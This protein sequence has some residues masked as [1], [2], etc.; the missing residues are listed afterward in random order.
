[1]ADRLGTYRKKRDFGTTPE[2]KGRGRKKAEA[3][4]FVVQEHSA[5]R[6]HWDLRLEHD[7]SLASWALPRG[8][9]AHPD[10]NRLAVQTED[11]PL[12]YLEFEGDIP[13]GEYGAGTMRVW[14]GGTY[15]AEKFR[16]GEV[17][18]TFNGER[19]RG[20][21]ALFRTRDKDW[22][23]HRMDPPED[24]GYQPMPDRLEPMLARS[25]KLPSNEQA[26]GF[27]VKWDGIRTLLFSDHGHITLQGRNFS[28]FTPRYPEVREFS[29][30][31]GARRLILDG[32]VVAFDKE[33]RPSFELL[34][35]RMHLASDSAVRRRMR[36]IP[37]TY[38]IFDLLY[39]DGRLTL[40]L[41]YEDRRTL[42]EE[43]E[44]EG[45]ALAH[46]RLPP[47]RGRRAA[48]GHPPAR[49]R[50][51]DREAARPPLRARPARLAL[52]Q[53][54]ER[55]DPGHRDRRLDSGG[56]R[57]QQHDRRPGGGRDGGGQARLRRQ[58]RHRLHRGD[59]RG[60]QARARAAPARHEPV[61]GAS[62]AEGDDLRRAEAGRRGRV[63]PVDEERDAARALLQGPAAGQGPARMHPRSRVS[64]Y[65][66]GIFNLMARA[67]WS[68]AISFGLVNIPVKLFSAVS[69][70]TVRFHQIDSKSGARIKQQR[71]NQDGEEVK[72][73]DIVK[74][75]EISPE[76]YVMIAPEELESLEPQKTR[77]ID[78]EAFVDLEQIDP[79]YYDHP[80]YLA[81]DKGAEKAYKLLVDAMDEASKVAVA[82]VVIRSKES[83]VA[84]RPR[85][86]ILA[87]ETMLFADEVI[88]P[89][90][91]DELTVDGSKT[92]KRELD[93]AKQLIDSLSADFEPEQYRD[94]YRE[95]VLEMIERKAAGETITIET[96]E[97]EPQ[98]VP[99]LMAAL[100]ASIAAS[101]GP[102]GGGSKR[103]TRSS[104]GS[105]S[106]S[107]KTASKS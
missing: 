49:H 81:P 13:K 93:M 76:R 96:P 85:A 106:S 51:R 67:I 58:G 90:S 39:L 98:K 102:S 60:P 18:A 69:R 43:L 66:G 21:Y 36:D 14:D 37:V 87:M 7:G 59:A 35:S 38:V 107:K 97:E 70:K 92:S 5:R 53:G 83:L 80:Y 82:R 65:S 72:Y 77:T 22:L 86:G 55:A 4:R 73:E 44:L 41:T 28:D 61:R 52:D 29:R 8:V 12:E 40:P 64:R 33:G 63:S 71:V 47:R 103:K 16:D 26:Y 11:H 99:D 3:P 34:Q 27:E 9:P 2:P 104:N 95:R 62:A 78:I 48:R 32:E 31:Q 46:A 105:K 74:G 91:L 20:R 89:D 100:E 54:Q 25:G 23:I 79:I 45:P 17:I 42:L 56:G 15:E 30:A 10:E 50:G 57:T 1:M 75:Y 88:N 19:M 24:P 101:K 68:G 94:E 6:L 84:L